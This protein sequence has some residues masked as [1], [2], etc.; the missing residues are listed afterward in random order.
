[1]GK[2]L[3]LAELA[4]RLEISS[5]VR[6][7]TLSLYRLGTTPECPCGGTAKSSGVTSARGTALAWAV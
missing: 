2:L 1:M 5:A 4:Y 6:G 7:Q 3:N